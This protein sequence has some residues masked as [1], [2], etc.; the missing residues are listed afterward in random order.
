MPVLSAECAG[1]AR[2]AGYEVR[3]DSEATVLWPVGGGRSWYRMRR[4]GDMGRV[5]LSET[6]SDGMTEILLFAVGMDVT[7]RFLI[8]ALGDDIRDHIDLPFLELPWRRA[9]DLA[10]GFAVSGVARGYR[11]LSRAGVGPI[12]AAAGDEPGLSRLVPLS[13]FMLLTLAELRRSFLAV[14]GAPL[15]A[16][17]RYRR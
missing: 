3:V 12:A 4:R 11:T 14:D 13:R 8:G 15:L 5:E 7:E 9:G 17:G 2:T 16:A 1:W 10:I 6:D